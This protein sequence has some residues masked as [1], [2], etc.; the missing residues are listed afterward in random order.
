VIVST[1]GPSGPAEFVEALLALGYSQ[2][3]ARCYVGLLS[4]S[5]QTGY[6]VSKL[7]G[8]P[9][10]KVYEA[11]R[12]LVDKGA[13]H[14]LAGEPARFTAVPPE[15]LLDNLQASF[16]LRLV[17]AREASADLHAPV[18]PAE[19]EPVIHL[20][21]RAAVLASASR[22]LHA[23]KRRVYLSGSSSELR[24]LEHAVVRSAESGVDIVVLCFGRMPFAAPGVRAFRHASTDGVVF[25]HHQSRHVALVADSRETVFGLAADGRAWTGI[26]TDS[27]PIIAAVKGYIRHDLEMQQVFRDFEHELVQAYG[28][29]LQGL[30]S[31]RADQP[32]RQ[33]V[34]DAGSGAEPRLQSDADAS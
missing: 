19:Q 11:L 13:A 4:P 5:P 12:K 18:P 29:G 25:R 17:R 30:E 23:A 2:Y 31:Y 27:E 32:A 15:E 6:G 3:E 10:P 33:P 24:S 1:G 16:D 22:A 8:V 14:Q 9:Q 7:T 28:P 21:D 34:G 20:S 26:Q